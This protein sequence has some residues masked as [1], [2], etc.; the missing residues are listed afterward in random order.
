VSYSAYGT[1]WG[2]N[3][4]GAPSSEAA[5]LPP[6]PSSKEEQASYPPRESSP[7]RS[8]G[9]PAVAGPVAGKPV[10]DTLPYPRV[11]QRTA[12]NGLLLLPRLFLRLI[13]LK[14]FPNWYTIQRTAR[15]GST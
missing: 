12:R 10:V 2:L 4:T 14:Q 1:K 13:W 7:D 3:E 9:A 15:N 8:G 5:P 6:I 11:I